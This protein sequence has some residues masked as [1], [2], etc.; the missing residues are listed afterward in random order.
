ML[1]GSEMILPVEAFR[2]IK[3]EREPPPAVSA[4]D[5][6]V[7]FAAVTGCEGPIWDEL[8]EPPSYSARCHWRELLRWKVTHSSSGTLYRYVN[9]STRALTPGGMLTVPTHWFCTSF[10]MSLF[11][12]PHC[13]R[14]RVAHFHSRHFRR[15][16]G[17][18]Q[19]D[20]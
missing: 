19:L 3:P 15:R 2:S 11:S 7:S 10:V 4:F 16:R 6:Q 13:V 1:G 17:C 20:T 18:S 9:F 5:S 8:A 12:G 14:W